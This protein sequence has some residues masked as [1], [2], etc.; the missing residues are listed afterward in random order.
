MMRLAFVFVLVGFGTKAGFAPLHTWLA[1][2]HSQAPSPVSAVLSGVLLSCALYGILRFHVLTTSATGGEFSSRH[3]LLAFG[4]LSV[5]IAA[6]FVDRP[7]RPETAARLFQRRA[8]GVDGGRVRHRRTAGCLRRVCSISSTTPR[9]RRLLFFVAGDLVQRFGT[10]RIS[11][12]RGA[13]R[14]AP[15]TGLGAAARGPRHHRCAAVRHLRQRVRARWGRVSRRSGR[16]S[17]RCSV[18]VPLLGLIFAGMLMQAL[19][20]VYGIPPAGLPGARAG[21]TPPRFDWRAQAT[22]L[23]ALAP[24]AI[25]DGALRGARAGEDCAGRCLRMSRL[26]LGP[27]MSGTHDRRGTERPGGGSCRGRVELVPAACAYRAWQQQWR[28]PC[29]DGRRRRSS[30]RRARFGSVMS[31]PCRRGAGSTV[32]TT[33]RWRGVLVS[34]R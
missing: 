13:I 30:A 1:D 27:V 33:G 20:V 3:L 28:S 23:V 7:A 34:R 21:G 11:A 10:R 16:R 22:T 12:I 4:V 14:L 8:Y 6:P 2:A 25:A 17:P 9:R 26:L 15:L 5:A 24:L 29:H 31:L 18:V 19:R 32:E